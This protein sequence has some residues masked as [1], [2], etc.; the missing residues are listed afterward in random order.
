M[1]HSILSIGIPY[2]L[3]AKLNMQH[4][5]SVM[6]RKEL[7][8]ALYTQ[9]IFGDIDVNIDGFK[10]RNAEILEAFMKTIG[11]KIEFTK[12]KKED[13][14][15]LLYDQSSK[16]EPWYDD[17]EATDGLSVPV[18]EYGKN[19]FINPVRYMKR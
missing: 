9:N 1:E 12:V 18:T 11:L 15:S 7:N 13:A 10:N 14:P 19:K 16:I 4:S 6:G 17:R 8:D 3:V 5:S 2:K